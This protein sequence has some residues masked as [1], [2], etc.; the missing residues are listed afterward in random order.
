MLARLRFFKR[1]VIDLPRQLR[2]GYCLMRD[3]RVPGKIKVAFGGGLGILLAPRT[4][5]PK[6]LP[7]LGELDSVLILILALR[8]FI[9]ACP[10]D[11]VLDV[12]QAIIEQRSVFD[13]DLRRGAAV[14]TSLY[15]RVRGMM[16]AADTE[17]TGMSASQ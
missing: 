2:L 10:D 11:V 1:L 8:L 15:A 14:A 4:R 3:P 7:M 17:P 9:A 12:E 16:C 6:S 5:L 13:D